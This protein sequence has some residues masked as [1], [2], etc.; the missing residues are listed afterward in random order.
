MYLNILQMAIFS[1]SLADLTWSSHV[2]MW[3]KPVPF[4]AWFMRGCKR[5]D[6][7]GF[8]LLIALLLCEW[9]FE[10]GLW[11]LL[12]DMAHAHGWMPSGNWLL[13]LSTS[14]R[15]FWKN[16]FQALESSQLVTAKRAWAVSAFPRVSSFQYSWI[17]LLL[18]TE[19]NLAK[20]KIFRC[21]SITRFV[22]TLTDAIFFS[23][24]FK[25]FM[26][27]LWRWTFPDPGNFINKANSEES[28]VSAV[29]PSPRQAL[30][31][32]A[33]AYKHA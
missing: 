11:A 10:S 33:H 19:K 29:Y 6:V 1:C 26:L 7:V 13:V 9:S 21:P 15:S 4:T 23:R 27:L 30:W 2:L 14:F 28:A 16:L 12:V 18:R 22:W 3:S 25:S 8:K 5:I 17:K 31:W 20:S 24:N 32:E